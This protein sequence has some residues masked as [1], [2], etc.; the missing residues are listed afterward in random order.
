MQRLR[1][2]HS[3]SQYRGQ[4]DWPAPHSWHL[5]SLSFRPGSGSA[6][7][8]G[9]ERRV[10]EWS[11]ASGAGH[12]TQGDYQKSHLDRLLNRFI[13]SDWILIS[14]NWTIWYGC[15]CHLQSVQ[16][17][18]Y[19]SGQYYLIILWRHCTGEWECGQDTDTSLGRLRWPRWHPSVVQHHYQLY[20]LYQ[21]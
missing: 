20:Q 21:F 3:T 13:F 4:L 14:A 1:A 16:Q 19:L 2:V 17:C 11:A 10:H 8:L 6:A 15:N 12:C 7:V 5:A 9:V 18:N